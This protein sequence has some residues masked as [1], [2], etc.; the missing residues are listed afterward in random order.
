M[1]CNG[2]YCEMCSND[3]YM[4]CYGRR[5]GMVEVIPRLFVGSY[6]NYIRERKSFD[7][8]VSACKEPCHRSA[9]G[10]TTN[11]APKDK[12]YYFVERGNQLILNLVDAHSVDYIPPTVIN[13]ALTTLR[14]RHMED[15]GRVLVHCNQ[16]HSRAPS[17]ALMYILLNMDILGKDY[18]K[19]VEKFKELYP[20]YH[21]NNGMRD[22]VSLFIKD[23]KR[24]K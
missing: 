21:P 7:Y 12:D 22:Y 20:R 2:G 16:G 24:K 11:A 5:E 3:I 4:K 14:K 23:K 18:D 19:V 10:Y 1:E 8:I 9:L 6:D 15:G 17:I 13:K